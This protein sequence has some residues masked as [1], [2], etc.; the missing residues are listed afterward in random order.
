VEDIGDTNFAQ[1]YTLNNDGS[2]SWSVD[3]SGVKHQ[4]LKTQAAANSLQLGQSGDVSEILGQ[5]KVDQ[6][7]TMASQGLTTPA[8]TD[9]NYN[10]P[11][12][13]QHA[14]QINSVNQMTL[15]ST[16]FSLISGITLDLEGLQTNVGGNTSGTA[17]IGEITT[18]FLKLTAIRFSSFQNNSVSDQFFSVASATNFA[19]C[20]GSDAPWFVTATSG[21]KHNMSV[22][23]ASGNPMPVG[24]Q[25]IGKF[26]NLMFTTTGYNQLVFLANDNTGPHNGMMLI[27]AV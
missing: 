11:S 3:R 18:G 23:S 20:I 9:M 2:C 19:I 14:F 17:F 15:T 24:S 25:S 21:T 12:G 6:L 22:P 7:L 4:V 27:A 10:A 8:A 26:P 16:L 13:Q 1:L 5:L